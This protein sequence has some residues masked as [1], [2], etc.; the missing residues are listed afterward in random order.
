LNIPD[1]AGF[2]RHWRACPPK[3][4][5]HLKVALLK[6]FSS[7]SQFSRYRKNW[8]KLSLSL[9]GLAHLFGVRSELLAS[10]ARLNHLQESQK[11]AAK[12]GG[13]LYWFPEVNEFW[14]SCRA[15]AGARNWLQAEELPHSLFANI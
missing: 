4:S 7:V 6:T 1:G 5:S 12:N 13:L 8:V 14:P 2:T 11:K 9:E 10:L 3:A 15:L